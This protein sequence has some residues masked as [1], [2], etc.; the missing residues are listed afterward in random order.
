MRFSLRFMP[1]L[2][3]PALSWAD[4]LA[5]LQASLQSLHG[6]SPVKV[7][8]SC[9]MRRERTDW[10]TPAIQEQWLR[11][12]VVEDERGLHVDLQPS[13]NPAHPGSSLRCQGSA[14]AAPFSG[15]GRALD[16]L[17]LSRLLNQADALSTLL[18]GARFKAER[19]ETYQG[20]PARVLSF[21]C[22]PQIQPQHQGRVTQSECN[23]QIWI[24]DDG[25]PLA[26]EYMLD[27]TGRHSR[28]YGRIHS[29]SFVRTTFT[30]RNQ[31]LFVASQ[32]SED[33]I[34]DYGN[35]L[36]CKE[37]LTLAAKG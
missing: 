3:L 36:K 32:T 29:A 37:V 12:D 1:L 19:R 6:H 28:L 14:S 35:R 4:G 11:A 2:F 15:I 17:A 8:G 16:P 5:D 20:S 33:F 9:E 7:S 18:E 10:M 27:Y 25:V 21:S 30:V 34:Y 23:L 13:A 24:G 26:A 31:R 22:A